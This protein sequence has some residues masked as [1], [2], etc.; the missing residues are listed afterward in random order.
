MRTGAVHESHRAA[1]AGPRALLRSRDSHERPIAA[2]EVEGRRIGNGD[3]ARRRV[4]E[5]EVGLAVV[6]EVDVPGAALL[7]PATIA[8]ASERASSGVSDS[9]STR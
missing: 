7:A 5:R 9:R 4:L 3:L 8:Y 2:V 6:V 1:L